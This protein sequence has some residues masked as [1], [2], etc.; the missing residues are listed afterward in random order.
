MKI[1]VG[2]VLRRIGSLGK[3]VTKPP[4]ALNQAVVEVDELRT[5]IGKKEMNISWHTP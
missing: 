1:A 2:T 5:F 3:K 4:I